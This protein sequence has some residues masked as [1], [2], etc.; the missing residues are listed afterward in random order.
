MGFLAVG[1]VLSTRGLKGEIRFKYYNE[2][3][4]NLFTYTALYAERD[5]ER[6][7]LKPTRVQS[8]RGHFLIRF[9]N[10][11][12]PGEASFLVGKELFVREVD[13]PRLSEGEYYDYQ[14]IGLMAVNEQ[15]QPIGRVKEVIHTKANDIIVI[16]GDTDMLVP[17]VEAFILK[18]DVNRAS[19]T[20]AESA[21]AE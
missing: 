21:F 10:V 14:L 18:V 17:L 2:S 12:T 9:S 13:L 7:E 11:R 4:C 6:V 3:E 15:R 20:V 1:R 19:I 5:G 16:G 8:Q